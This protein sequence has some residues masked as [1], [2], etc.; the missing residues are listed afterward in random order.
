MKIV[1]GK[2]KQF[3]AL[4]ELSLVASTMAE[5]VDPEIVRAGRLIA[6]SLR[7]GGKVLACGNGGSAADAQHFVAELVGRL[8][9]ERRSFPAISRRS[10]PSVVTA[11]GNDYGYEHLFSRKMKV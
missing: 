8:S 3:A 1:I 7:Q 6:G 9:I 4:R 11:V 10:D 2:W 5:K